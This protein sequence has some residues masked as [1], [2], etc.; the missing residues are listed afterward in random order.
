MSLRDKNGKS[1]AAPEAIQESLTEYLMG[2]IDKTEQRILF[3]EKERD[4]FV[5]SA[6]QFDEMIG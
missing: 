4:R 1:N 3:Y 2:L 6:N 5:F